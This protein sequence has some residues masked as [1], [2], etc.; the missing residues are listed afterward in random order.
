MGE[1]DVAPGP[2]WH[3]PC[4]V[5]TRKITLTE[6]IGERFREKNGTVQDCDYLAIK[7]S[8]REEREVF[9]A[10]VTVAALRKH[11]IARRVEAARAALE[12]YADEDP[13][14]YRVDVLDEL[15]SHCADPVEVYIHGR[16]EKWQYDKS[17]VR[18]IYDA[19]GEIDH[20]R[21][22]DEFIQRFNDIGGYELV[23]TEPWNMTEFR[24]SHSYDQLLHGILPGLVRAASPN[25]ARRYR[26]LREPQGAVRRHRAREGAP[27]RGRRG[28]RKAVS[29]DASVPVMGPVLRRRCMA[30]RRHPAQREGAPGLR[31]V[32]HALLGTGP[33]V[34][35]RAAL[36]AMQV[37]GTVR[38]TERTKLD[39]EGEGEGERSRGHAQDRR[40]Q[41]LDRSAGSRQ[42][43]AGSLHRA[44]D[45]RW[46]DKPTIVVG[47]ELDLSTARKLVSEGA[48]DAKTTSSGDDADHECHWR[49]ATVMLA[50][51]VV[52]T[53]QTGGKIG[54][55]TG[56]VMRVVDGKKSI[57]HW[58]KD[59][60]EALA[61]IGIEMVDKP[62][63]RRGQGA[64]AA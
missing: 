6:F 48:L 14:E 25:C 12:Y 59:F 34:R 28:R 63:R 45:L 33:H 26:S 9:D 47:R 51:C 24:S 22:H 19:L 62:T 31:A 50:K 58:D 17:T 61:F 35:C 13:E 30:A 11:L 60:V 53:L 23:T 39:D 4:A 42:W 27:A 40:A 8:S 20:L 15:P 46:A 1:V 57:E 64:K 52:A 3:P 55:G 41:H 7:L 18:G 54:M 5:P 49:K 56:M 43:Q 32:L 44:S 10:E 16:K 36:L 29:T 2:D 38:T 21:S 37:R